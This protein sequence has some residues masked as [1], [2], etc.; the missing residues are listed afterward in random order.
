[1]YIVHVHNFVSISFCHMIKF[2]YLYMYKYIYTCKQ[3]M[4]MCIRYTC[5]YTVTPIFSLLPVIKVSFASTNPLN[6]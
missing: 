2:V 4:Y 6:E 3:Y 1:M 5:I